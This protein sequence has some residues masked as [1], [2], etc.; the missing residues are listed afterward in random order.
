MNRFVALLIPVLSVA[1]AGVA[2][3]RLSNSESNTVTQSQRWA[4]SLEAEKLSRFDVAAQESNAYA[5]EGGDAYLATI[6]SAWLAYLQ[7]DY[8]KA[9]DAYRSASVLRNTAV[10]P[11][12]GLLSVAQASGDAL[13]IQSA[14]EA[15]LRMEPTNYKALM[16]VAVG[17]FKASNYRLAVADYRR[18]LNVYPGELDAMSGLGWASYYCGDKLEAARNFQTILSLSPTYP[19]AQSGYNLAA[20]P[21]QPVTFNA[22]H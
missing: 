16:A 8:K 1:A 21:N 19:E 4:A 20:H 3:P 5:R 22:S 12:Q 2:S 13:K 14:A 15:L 6:R 7:S 10:A 11:L 18:V 17:H 9:A